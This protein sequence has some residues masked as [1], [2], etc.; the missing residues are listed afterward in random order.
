MSPAVCR[1]HTFEHYAVEQYADESTRQEQRHA[2]LRA[3]PT[4]GR[5]QRRQQAR[6]HADQSEDGRGRG[7]TLG[8]IAGG[9]DTELEKVKPRQKYFTGTARNYVGGVALHLSSVLTWPWLKHSMWPTRFK[10]LVITHDELTS[11]HVA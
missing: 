6:Q 3:E 5:Q 2:D 8:E 10:K 1:Q 11:V 4:T 7:R 9:E